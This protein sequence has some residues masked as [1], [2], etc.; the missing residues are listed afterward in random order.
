MK[1]K[2]IYN[3]VCQVCGNRIQFFDSLGYSEVHHIIPHGQPHY[4]KDDISNMIV[5][6]PN[7]HVLFDYGIISIEPIKMILRHADS[8][9]KLNGKKVFVVKHNINVESLK[10]HNDNIFIK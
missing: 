8:N 1:L 7:C 10:Y 9:N 3:D 4:G 5:L 6:C 2:K